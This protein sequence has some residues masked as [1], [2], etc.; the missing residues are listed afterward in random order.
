MNRAVDLGLQPSSASS[1]GQAG[2]CAPCREPAVSTRLLAFSGRGLFCRESREAVDHGC[3]LQSSH[4]VQCGP[5]LSW[6]GGACGDHSPP[7]PERGF[8]CQVSR[9]S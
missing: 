6:E 2:A 7:C 5:L 8:P 9:S 3:L 4:I 1:S